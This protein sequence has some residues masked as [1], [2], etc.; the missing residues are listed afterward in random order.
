MTWPGAARRVLFSLSFCLCALLLGCSEP[1]DSEQVA[2]CKVV[3]DYVAFNP[4]DLTYVAIVETKHSNEPRV[5]IEFAPGEPGTGFVFKNAIVGGAVPKEYVPGV[6]KGLNMSKDNGLLAG[7]PLIDF[8]ATL[9]DGAYHDV[10]SNVLTFQI[11]SQA[12]FRELKEKGDPKLL[13]PIM[14][15]EVTSPEE[16]VGS[17]IGDL[18]SRRGMIQGMDD[19]VGGIKVVKAE[20][21]LAE[22]FGYSTTLRSLT[23]GRATYSME[24]KHYSEAPKNV[25]DAIINKK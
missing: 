9:V 17:V 14:K 25:A 4:S 13:E 2:F 8:T 22:M 20:V 10:D 7:F 24:F 11:A 15:V 6:E 18:N 1:E 5:K 21:P 23:Q 16:Y 19:Q 12:A 3:V